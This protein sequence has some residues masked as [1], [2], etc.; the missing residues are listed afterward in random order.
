MSLLSSSAWAQ[1]RIATIDL[2]KVFDSYWKTKQAQARR[3]MPFVIRT[4]CQNVA[5]RV[6]ADAL[7][8][9]GIDA[10]T[11]EHRPWGSPSTSHELPAAGSP[12]VST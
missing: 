10:R 4:L 6:Q 2:R 9:T 5:A 11:G 12:F 3:K 8:T 7:N 1:G